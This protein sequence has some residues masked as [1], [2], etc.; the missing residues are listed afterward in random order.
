MLPRIPCSE[1]DYRWRQNVVRTKSDAEDAAEC[2]IDFLTFW[3][4]ISE[5]IHGNMETITSYVLKQQNVVNG[6]LICASVLQ[7][8]CVKTNQNV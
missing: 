8:T 5:Q 3:W 7:W 4:S 2:V 1:I 6:D